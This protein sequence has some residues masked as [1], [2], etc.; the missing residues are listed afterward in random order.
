VLVYGALE[1]MQK[2]SFRIRSATVHVHFLEAVETAG[3]T[4]T[5]GTS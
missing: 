4:T 5:G 3:S 2:G 1:V